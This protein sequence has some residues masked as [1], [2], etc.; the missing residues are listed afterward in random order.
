MLNDRSITR[1]N[2]IDRLRAEKYGATA[3]CKFT[4]AGASPARLTILDKQVTHVSGVAQSPTIRASWVWLKE[5]DPELGRELSRLHLV[6]PT[7]VLRTH[8]KVATQWEFQGRV[9]TLSL[10]DEALDL[11]REWLWDVEGIRRV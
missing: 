5:R 11:A 7:N 4:I 1:A 8:L 2:A 6:D 9:Y 10:E 3:S